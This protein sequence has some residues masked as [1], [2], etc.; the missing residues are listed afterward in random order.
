MIDVV[1]GVHRP[2][3]AG[4]QFG[5]P[6]GQL[7]GPVLRWDGVS[8]QNLG[9]TLSGQIEGYAST[10]RDENRPLYFMVREV[11]AEYAVAK[12]GAGPD[13]DSIVNVVDVKL[14]RVDM[15]GEYG[16]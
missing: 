16:L 4:G 12:S 15:S 10:L 3:V 5:S 2:A 14:V 13:T 1:R 7:T 6:G 11:G 9:T 8:W